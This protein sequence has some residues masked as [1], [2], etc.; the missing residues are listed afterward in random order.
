MIYL[1]WQTNLRATSYNFALSAGIV[2]E[3]LKAASY[4][5]ALSASIFI[6]TTN[7]KAASYNCALSAGIVKEIHLKLPQ[8]LFPICPLV[9]CL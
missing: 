2:K 5:F 3:N 1:L 9:L 6:V 8:H 7:L 4:N